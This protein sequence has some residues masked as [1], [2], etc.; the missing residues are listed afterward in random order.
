MVNILYFFKYLWFNY[1]QFN[2]KSMRIKWFLNLNQ[3]FDLN[4][5]INLEE[6]ILIN[7]KNKIILSSNQFTYIIDAR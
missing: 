1:I 6:Q 5:A 2:N 4:Q 7:H 3:S